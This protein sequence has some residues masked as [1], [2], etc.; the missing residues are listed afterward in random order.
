M[1]RFNVKEIVT[2]KLHLSTDYGRMNYDNL[3]PV[4]IHAFTF[5]YVNSYTFYTSNSTFSQAQCFFRD[6]YTFLW[7]GE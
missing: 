2:V 3:M 5:F 6:L 1:K 7:C 4:N